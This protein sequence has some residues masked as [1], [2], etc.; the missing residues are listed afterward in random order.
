VLLYAGLGY[1]TIYGFL[2][3]ITVYAIY[4]VIWAVYTVYPLCSCVPQLPAQEYSRTQSLRML[5]T[6]AIAPLHTSLSLSL[7]RVM[8]LCSLLSILS[9]YSREIERSQNSVLTTLCTSLSL[10]LRR[11]RASSKGCR[12][13]R[14]VYPSAWSR[15][16][17]PDVEGTYA[18]IAFVTD[19]SASSHYIPLCLSLSLERCLSALCSLF[20]LSTL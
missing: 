15:L 20:S 7:S 1:G 5:L 19:L 14:L 10:S 4:G 2:T 6:S 8:P 9:L 11:D 13:R 16:H 18:I 12:R 17:H 3:Q